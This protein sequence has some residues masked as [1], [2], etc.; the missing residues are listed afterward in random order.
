MPFHRAIAQ[1]PYQVP[2]Y[3]SPNSSLDSILKYG[4]FNSLQELQAKST[5][6]LQE[7]NALIV[8]NA[9]P[10]GNFLFGI[11][12]D[13]DYVPN[14]P[15][16]LLLEGRFENRLSIMT[17]H[18]QNEASRFV[19]NRQIINETQYGNFLKEFF[20]PLQQRPDQLQLL[21]QQLYPS[22]FN[23]S[24][25]YTNQVERTNLTFADA[26]YVSN[27]R[28]LNAAAFQGL[29]YAYKFTVPPAVHGTD[30]SYTFFE[31]GDVPGVNPGVAITLQKYITNFALTGDLNGAGL[32]L[33]PLTLKG[34]VVQKI[35]G[36][37]IGPMFDEGGTHQ[38][39]QR[40]QF[41]QKA[42]YLTEYLTRL[43]FCE[44]RA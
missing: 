6:E 41:W 19:P 38:V 32:L 26:L 27:A 23:G 29:G 15:I 22:D 17:G 34:A 14:L 28:A 9:R 10:F 36:Q 2:N 4:K 20:P 13:G 37:G 43:K 5:Q 42:S 3:P 16:K 25:W 31:T 40:S 33:F 11:I 44:T 1:S 7:L 12:V 8:G 21:T 30:L 35:G 39:T 18:N 24:Q